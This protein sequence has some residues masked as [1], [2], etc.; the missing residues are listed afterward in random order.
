MRHIVFLAV[1]TRLL[2]PH[3]AAAQDA[4]R[5]GI[6][7]GYPAAA[8]VLWKVSGRLAV[9]PEVSLTKTA[10][11]STTSIGTLL[12]PVGVVDTTTTTKSDGWQ[13]GVGASVLVYLSKGDALKTYVSPRYAYSRISTTIESTVSGVGIPVRVGPVSSTSQASNHAA[14]GSFGA[15]Y[16][17]GS[18]FGVF[19]ELG[20][21][22]THSGEMPAASLSATATSTGSNWTIGLRSGAGVI[23]FF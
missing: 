9:R 2:A 5:F 17:V 15:Q 18:R 1:V 13:V 4:P 20:L 12:S 14:S 19:G 6:V 8:G 11:E 7:M 3:A 16:S 21:S 22:Y 10:S 23:L